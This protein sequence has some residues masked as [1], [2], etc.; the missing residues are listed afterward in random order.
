MRWAARTSVL[1]YGIRYSKWEK[2]GEAVAIC[3]LRPA[4]LQAIDEAVLA[5][6]SSAGSCQIEELIQFG[7]RVGHAQEVAAIFF[8]PLRAGMLAPSQARDMAKAR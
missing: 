4:D 2:R 6:E 5:G 1:L 3:G 7:Q 8:H